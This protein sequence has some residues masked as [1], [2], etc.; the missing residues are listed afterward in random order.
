M[1]YIVNYILYPI[2]YSIDF[3]NRIYIIILH[4]IIYVICIVKRI[5]VATPILDPYWT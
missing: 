1:M 5:V 2:I 4:V 3:I